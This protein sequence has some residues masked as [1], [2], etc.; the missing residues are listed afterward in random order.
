MN[1]WNV[2]RRCISLQRGALCERGEWWRVEQETVRESGV[3]I[4]I[5]IG[6]KIKIKIKSRS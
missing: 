1:A 5:G 4:R 3:G 6:I 2:A